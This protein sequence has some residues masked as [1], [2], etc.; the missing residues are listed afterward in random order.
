MQGNLILVNNLFKSNE[1][2]A[3]CMTERAPVYTGNASEPFLHRNR[4][5]ILVHTEQ[6]LKRNII[7]SGTV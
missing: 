5:L 1:S 4:T 2:V 3:N 7:L 6:L